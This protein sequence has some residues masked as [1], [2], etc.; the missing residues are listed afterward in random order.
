MSDPD[1]QETIEALKAH[2]KAL[3]DAEPG[4]IPPWKTGLPITLH[5]T[6]TLLKAQQEQL[7]T[8][9]AIVNES[10]G[11]VG[12]HLNGDVAEWEDF[13]LAPPQESSD[14]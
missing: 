4:G 6:I 8:F 11:V 7:D 13:D 3:N 10:Q 2:I 5:K 9:Y 14:E 1:L 12:W